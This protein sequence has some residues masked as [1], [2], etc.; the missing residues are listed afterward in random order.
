MHRHKRP[1]RA[2]TAGILLGSII[3]VIAGV[4]I[5]REVGSETPAQEKQSLIDRLAATRS[6]AIQFASEHPELLPPAIPT[7]MPTVEPTSWSVGLIEDAYLPGGGFSVSNMW[8]WDLGGNHVQVFA[9]GA[10]PN[11]REAGRGSLLVM[12]RSMDLKVLTELG[13]AY[14]A[15][16]D[17]GS[18]RITS[19]KGTL[20]T[21]E[22]TT[23]ETFYFD[24]ET[25]DFTD[26]NGDPVPT[27]TPT[28]SPLP[29]PPLP[30][31]T[32]PLPPTETVAP[33][34]A[35]AVPAPSGFAN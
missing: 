6:A 13:G 9:G 1:V 29:S 17:V 30:S 35:S 33:G 8:S 34:T 32:I 3:L 25:R 24:A 26:A 20:L 4:A 12:V 22:A 16:P 18:L 15:P 23:G 11:V 27:D 7:T 5:V 10:G 28:P 2:S 21:V 14:K 19:F 31:V